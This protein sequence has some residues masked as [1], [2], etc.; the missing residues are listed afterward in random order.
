MKLYG[1]TEAQSTHVDELVQ[2]VQENEETLD[3]IR[4]RN[5]SFHFFVHKLLHI[6]HSLFTVGSNAM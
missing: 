2:L 5:L 6:M 4:V 3:L 1:I